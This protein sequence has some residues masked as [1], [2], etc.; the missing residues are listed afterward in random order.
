MATSCVGNDLVSNRTT[1]LLLW[2]LPLAAIV[3]GIW[4]GP[5]MRTALWTP[6]FLIMGGACV[7]NAK[8]CGRLHCYLTGPL[9]LVAGAATLLAGLGVI[10]IEL[11]WI[12]RAAGV[13]TALAFAVEW[14]RGK[15]VV[16]GEESVV[17]GRAA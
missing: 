6:S 3:L 5:G 13:G 17:A 2:G 1:R 10:P 11:S 4:F 14:L 8:H 15:Y 7:Y 9:F 12:G 16:R